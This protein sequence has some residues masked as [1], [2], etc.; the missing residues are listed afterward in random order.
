MKGNIQKIEAYAK[1]ILFQGH[2]FTIIAIKGK[3]FPKMPNYQCWE[4]F[5]EPNDEAGINRY[6]MEY[7][8]G[9]PCDQ[10]PDAESALEIA[11]SYNN[12]FNALEGL[13]EDDGA[14]FDYAGQ[15]D[16]DFDEECE[17]GE[18]EDED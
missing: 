16:F 7:M 13:I 15:E 9:L 14:W 8:F 18:C 6:P 10:T 12:V 1:N 3:D 2:P 4:C 11:S 5:I 17:D